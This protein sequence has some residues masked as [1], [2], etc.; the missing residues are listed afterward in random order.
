[1]SDHP[2]T[3]DYAVHPG[4]VIA[5]MLEEA[6]MKQAH[7]A[8]ACRVSPKHMNLVIHGHAPLHAEMAVAI[9]IAMGKRVAHV[10][11]RMQSDYDVFQEREKMKDHAAAVGAL[12]VA[13]AGEDK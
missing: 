13:L 4:G 5:E 8:G 12:Y 2:Y 1:M 9:E 10:L 6:G 7:L 11:M 3:P